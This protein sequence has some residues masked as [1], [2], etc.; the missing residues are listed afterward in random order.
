MDWTLARTLLADEDPEQVI[1]E[2]R[3][4]RLRHPDLS[5]DELAEKM[6]RRA[7][8]AC[9]VMGAVASAPAGFL[10]SFSPA[11][12]LSYQALRLHRLVLSIARS[13]SGRPTTSLERGMTVAGSLAVSAT[14]GWLR[15]AILRAARRPLSRRAPGLLPL[16][17]ALIGGALSY[18]AARG[19]GAAARD[20]CRAS[21]RRRSWIK[22]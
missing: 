2:V 18:A 7:A 21:R 17:S 14:T 20:Y 5:D 1:R 19:V 16:A 13:Y 4:I 22:R 3:K 12:D 11:A 10:L 9:A 8:V 15:R 6:I